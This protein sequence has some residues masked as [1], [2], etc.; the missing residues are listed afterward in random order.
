MKIILFLFFFILIINCF[1]NIN[2]NINSFGLL[3]K[4]SVILGEDILYSTSPH[5]FSRSSGVRLGGKPH[6][7][8]RINNYLLAIDGK[9]YDSE[10]IIKNICE[11]LEK[12]IINNVFIHE[13]KVNKNFIFKLLKNN[14]SLTSNSS[15]IT[16]SLKTSTSVPNDTSSSTESIT[17]SSISH[18][19]S[20]ELFSL[21][22]K[23]NQ[24]LLVGMLPNQ[25]GTFLCHFDS[26][27]TQSMSIYERYSN[28][29]VNLSDSK[30]IK[31]K[32]NLTGLGYCSIGSWKESLD[33][34]FHREYKKDMTT[35]NL[36]NLAIRVGEEGGHRNLACGGGGLRILLLNS[37]GLFL[38]D[39]E[40]KLR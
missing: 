31:E 2:N 39:N 35:E 17:P 28:N 38:L 36:L 22:Y 37:N 40:L 1:A 19:I 21:S 27:G 26:I 11:K 25:Q 24:I 15:S 33:N 7:L 23:I 16:S 9:D 6:K 4:D 34:F 10:E 3:G 20:D 32:S 5:G 30:S 18:I 8:F 14:S 29:C 12:K 13:K